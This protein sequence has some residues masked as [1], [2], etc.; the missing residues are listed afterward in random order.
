MTAKDLTPS[1]KLAA[2]VWDREDPF[3]IELTVQPKH[4]DAL[5]HTNN[6]HYLAWLQQ[7]A[8]Q[9]STARGFDEQQM[10]ALDRAMVVRE[11]Q[12][13]YLAATFVD[14]TLQ[15]GDWITS[16]DRRLRATREFQI[17][18]TSCG[19][20]IMRARIDYICMRISTGRPTRMPPEFLAANSDSAARPQDV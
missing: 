16:T 5:G 12:M 4:I 2:E 20:C 8:W 13:Q 17:I 3:I 9:H 14:D 6:L 1:V 7:C 15:V 11:T 10:V 19:T 18:R